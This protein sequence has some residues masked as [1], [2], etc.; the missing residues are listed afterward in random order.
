MS[1][2]V[3]IMLRDASSE[4]PRLVLPTLSRKPSSSASVSWSS[5]N[6]VVPISVSVA[7]SR[8]VAFGFSGMLMRTASQ[9]SGT[10]CPSWLVT[11]APESQSAPSV[12]STAKR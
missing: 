4:T 6:R 11:S 9:L 2:S 1:M 8:T 7:R 10:S 5:A 12:S 3:S